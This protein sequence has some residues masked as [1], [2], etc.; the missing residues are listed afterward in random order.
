MK[1]LIILLI[2]MLFVACAKKPPDDNNECLCCEEAF[3][4]LNTGG[5]Y[6][7]NCEEMLDTVGLGLK[8]YSFV[9]FTDEEWKQTSYD[10]KLK[11]RQIPEEFLSEMTAKELFYQYFYCDLN[12]LFMFNTFQQGFESDKRM[13]MLPELLNRSNAGHVLLELLRKVDPSKINRSDCFR[14][15]FELQIILAQLEVINRMTD[16][17]IDNY[18]IEQM[19][20]H[21][22]IRLL[23]LCD[24]E[25]WKYPGSARLILFG[26]GNVMIR[27]EFEPFMQSL[28][29]HPD[30]N[31][32][33]WDPMFIKKEY[34]L[35][36]IDYVEQ[37]I[38]NK[39]K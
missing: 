26:L 4:K 5:Y 21:D 8:L 29:R 24:E 36:V 11:R 34:A 33:I 18:I 7:A 17:D 35:Q 9:P 23:S 31:E 20:C 37:F 30:T 1:R 19:R 3:D 28:F 15:D 13:N 12:T 14:W 22:V 27:Y 10:Y 16:E 6:F 25:N 38:K 39:K 32:V 2:A